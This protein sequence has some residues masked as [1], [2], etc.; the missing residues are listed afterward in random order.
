MK[1]HIYQL[2]EGRRERI[3]HMAVLT[4][5]R[6]TRG[7]LIKKRFRALRCKVILIQAR[8][9]GYLAR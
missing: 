3:V 6:Y 7:F 5:Q 4:L 1:E 2:L 8:C 9:R